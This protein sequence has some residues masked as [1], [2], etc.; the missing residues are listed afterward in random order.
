M[1]AA[2][3]FVTYQPVQ[4]SDADMMAGEGVEMFSSASIPASG[5]CLDGAGVEMFSSASTPPAGRR[6]EDAVPVCRA[7]GA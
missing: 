4:D 3:K 6:W 2:R 5:S 7:S 1:T